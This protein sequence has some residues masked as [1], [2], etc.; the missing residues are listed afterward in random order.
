MLANKHPLYAAMYGKQI[1]LRHCYEGEE[2][3]KDET[4]T[5][6]PATAG[7]E[8]DGMKPGDIGYKA[9]RAYLVRAVFHNFIRE[10]VDAFIGL[11]HQKPPVIELPS[12]MEPLREKGSITGESLNLILRRINVEQLITGRVGILADLAV[13]VDQ[14]NP[15]PYLAIYAA[16]RIQ[17]WD[18]GSFEDGV[19]SL[20]LVV[21]NE[22]SAKRQLDFSWSMITKYR[23]LQLGAADANEVSAVYKQG[24]FGNEDY[25][26]S[27]MSS[28][29][30]RGNTLNEI[31]FVFAN[32]KDVLSEPDEPPLLTLANLCLAIYRG[33]AD[34]RQNLYM[35]SQDTLVV[36]GTITNNALPEEGDTDAV[37]IGAGSRINVDMGGDAKFIGV[38]ANGLSEQRQ[39]LAADKS[40]ATIKA[41]QML[42]PTASTQESGQ[43]LKTRIG[44]QTATLNQ[45][46]LTGAEALQKILRIVATWMGAD[47]KQVTVTPN[48]E[49]TDYD[50]SGQ[51]LVF[52][53]TARAQGAPISLESIHKLMADRGI[54][55]ME[56][57][58]EFA[59]WQTEMEES[60][61][62]AA[63]DAAIAQSLKTPNNLNSVNVDGNAQ[64][65]LNKPA[66]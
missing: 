32:T 17:N 52:L 57:A 66:V 31:P 63:E 55:E 23:V 42:S 56:F 1:K 40:A 29:S 21:I 26:E 59:K 8:L 38:S 14:A 65:V 15:L 36:V 10:A 4:T 46:A 49:F 34:Y 25:V 64:K 24:T 12:V 9:Y 39:A 22:T 61:K 27:Q 54:T 37:R 45:V 33:E 2:R 62:I 43:A 53:M 6:L 47:P 16:E 60:R 20:N 18:D 58:S 5:Y 48:L 50:I 41:G 19:N 7:M 11:L 28:P 44:A 51:D 13:N 3:I 35:Q 30:I